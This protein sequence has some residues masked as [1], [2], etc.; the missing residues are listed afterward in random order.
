M[1]LSN[2]YNNGYP[3]G[4]WALFRVNSLTI[5]NQL[6][7]GSSNVTPLAKYEEATFVIAYSGFWSAPITGK[8]LTVTKIGNIVTLQFEQ[9]VGVCAVGNTPLT[10]GVDFNL[11]TRFLPAPYGGQNFSSA[12]YV[13]T[14]DGV[15]PAPAYKPAVFFCSPVGVMQIQQTDGN[16][17]VG[18]NAGIVNFCVTYQ[19]ADQS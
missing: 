6:I 3:A 4:E 8:H 14:Y 11:P 19:A 9:A 15:N 12:Q 5:D 1:S 7:L 10:L 17:N 18:Q 13:F 16:L 2:I